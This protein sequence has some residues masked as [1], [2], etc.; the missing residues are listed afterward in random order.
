MQNNDSSQHKKEPQQDKAE[1]FALLDF[2]SDPKTFEQAL[3]ELELPEQELTWILAELLRAGALTQTK[4]KAYV[5]VKGS[6]FTGHI[7]KRRHGGIWVIPDEF[8]LPPMKIAEQKNVFVGDWVLCSYRKTNKRKRRGHGGKSR[9]KSFRAQ[10]EHIIKKRPQEVVGIYQ[11]SERGYPRLKLQG[12]N[13]PRY[14]SLASELKQELKEG[15]LVKATFPRKHSARRPIGVYQETLSD[16]DDPENDLDFFITLY[17]LPQAFSQEAEQQAQ[18]IEES[19]PQQELEKRIDLRSLCTITIDPVGAKDHDDAIS[20]EKLEHNRWR[21]GVHIADLSFYVKRQSALW[22]DA[23]QRATSIYLP[24]MTIPMLPPKL[25]SK[26]CSLQAGETRLTKSCFMTFDQQGKLLRREVYPSFIRVRRYLTYQKAHDL[27]QNKQNTEEPEIVQ[28]LQNASTIATSLRQKRL[29]AG[30]FVLSIDRPKIEL[31]AQGKIT[32]VGPEEHS[33]THSIIEEFMLAANCTVAQFM[34]E[35]KMPYIARAHPNP[36]PEAEE[37][38]HHFCDQLGI[39]APDFQDT[40]RIQLF[41]EGLEG[42]P[43]KSAIHLALLKTMQRAQYTDKKLPHYALAFQE[44]THFTSPI[45]RLCDLTIHQILHDYWQAGGVLKHEESPTAEAWVDHQDYDETKGIFFPQ[46]EKKRWGFFLTMIAKQA[47][48]KEVRAQK[49]EMNLIQLKLLRFM[50]NKLGQNFHATLTH[51][52]SRGLIL[53]LDDIL[54]EGVLPYSELK[55]EWLEF[56]DF[57]IEYEQK[58]QEKKLFVGDRLQVCAEDV[59]LVERNL[60]LS[61]ISIEKEAT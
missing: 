34:L 24:G 23:Y 14:L 3:T 22:N 18:A 26:L 58:G 54:V 27:L 49:A 59:D 48:E 30:S 61:L 52:T 9:K 6:F 11:L 8:R 50:Q 47:S 37:L 4:N 31:D 28:L 19:I 10:V 17:D 16:L 32:K 1:A 55:N 12:R 56:H 41:L 46:A 40:R 38:F 25:S 44:Y 39:A 35:R 2:F 36:S 57:W 5:K 15:Q 60:D 43:G 51:I 20:I 29:Q 33:F 13:K 42:H 21:V 45:R 53:Q 7:T